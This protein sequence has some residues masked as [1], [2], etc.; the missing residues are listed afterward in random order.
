MSYKVVN[1]L[2]LP[3]ILMNSNHLIVRPFP[4]FFTYLLS[5]SDPPSIVLK[6]NQAYL[7]GVY[8]A[9]RAGILRQNMECLGWQLEG[10]YQSPQ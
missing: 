6:N 5:P 7:L 9:F 3:S 8:L 10:F 1:S 4:Q 2:T